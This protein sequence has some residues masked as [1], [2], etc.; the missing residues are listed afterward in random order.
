MSTSTTILGADI[1]YRMSGGANN[2]NPAN[3]IGGPISLVEPGELN[4]TNGVMGAL[5]D[6]VPLSEATAGLAAEFRCI[7]AYNANENGVKLVNA[8]LWFEGLN[9]DSNIINSI[10]LDPSGLN[11][12]AQTI[13]NETT[14][15]VGVTFVQ[16]TTKHTGLSLGTMSAG[17]FYPFW[18]KRQ[19]QAS[20]TPF[21]QDSFRLRI[22]GEPPA[23]G[24]PPPP[25][26]PGSPP[27]PPPPPGSG[28]SGGDFGFAA[29]AKWSCN[30]AAQ[31]NVTNIINRLKTTP[32]LGP[33]IPGGD[34]AYTIDPTCWF[35]MTSAIDHQTH[36]TLG[37]MEQDTELGTQPAILNNWL[38]HYSITSTYY[39]FDF[40]DVHFLIL[41]TEIPFDTT[42][43]QYNF[44]ALDLAKASTNSNID[45][46]VVRYHQPMYSAG[47]N[48]DV[49][50]FNHLNWA[51]TY[52]PLFDTY[53]V[54]LVIQG[55]PRNYQRTL[56][57]KFTPG[58]PSTPTVM[59]GITGNDY[60]NP[61]GVIYLVVG[62]GGH[63][64][65]TGTLTSLPYIASSQNTSN[66]YLYVTITQT[67][68]L[69][70]GSFYNTSNNVIDKF[71]IT[72]V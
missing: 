3:S 70:T 10:G 11:G 72:K 71:T 26:P 57:V 60:T 14:A 15:P 34:I 64:L 41:N 9:K 39:S 53:M 27:P 65:D 5:W 18:L 20:S 61:N 51:S 56:P 31:T 17:S 59:S 68:S 22:E 35:N 38:H 1:Q 24:L 30:T 33:F 13:A 63:N 42:T 8:I 52:G 36:I 25:G 45:W 54:D 50:G 46:I 2:G 55:H 4:L 32:P 16:P 29:A 21:F 58:T 44:A 66:G 23:A 48:G 7:Y 49:N 28:G 19:I 62:T 6:F 40:N 43:P 47:G 12:T 37:T 67:G 69:M